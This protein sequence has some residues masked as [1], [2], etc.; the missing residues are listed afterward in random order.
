MKILFLTLVR[1]E[2]LEDHGIYHDLLRKFRDNNHEVNIV[3]PSERKYG[4]NTRLYSKENVNILN[5]WTPNIQKTNVIEK[6]ISTLIIEYLYYF[7]IRKYINFT[8]VDLILY[9]TPPI[10]FTN[11]I[12]KLKQS[13]N[14]ITYLLL[15]DIFPQNA[16]DLELF[17]SDGFLYKYFRAKEISLYKISNFIGCMSPANYKYLIRNNQQ[18]E[19][20]KL[21]INPNTIEVNSDF[22]E[23]DLDLYSKYKIPTDKIIYLFGGNLGIPQGINYLMQNIAYC[24]SIKEAFFLIVGDGT[25]FDLLKKWIDLEHIENAQLIKEIPKKDFDGIL[26]LADVGLIFLNPRFTIPNFPSRLLS[27]MQYKLPVICATDMVSDIGDIASENNFGFKCLASDF[28]V[29]YNYVVKLLNKNLR[30][31]MGENAI[32]FLHNEYNV[33]LSYAKIIEKGKICE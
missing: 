4:L 3:C 11:L 21:E 1:V 6:G 16:V 19:T 12:Q 28:E 8:D 33:E 17:K 5:V 7:A 32:T 23:V 31:E 15:K 24:K 20:F 18:L 27:Y 25:E 9:S 2:N 26:R 30:I 29:F 10:T 13:S 14:A 22:P